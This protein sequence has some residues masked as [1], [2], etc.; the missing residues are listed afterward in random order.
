M[1]YARSPLLLIVSFVVFSACAKHSSDDDSSALTKEAYQ[2]G[3]AELATCSAPAVSGTTVTI[4][5]SATFHARQIFDNGNGDSGLGAA[6]GTAFPIRFAEIQVLRTDGSVAQCAQTDASGHFSFTLVK[7]NNA[8]TIAIYSRTPAS[9]THAHVSV[10][11]RPSQNQL[12]SVQG[13]VIAKG[14]TDI[15]VLDAPVTGN[16]LGGAFNIMDQIIRANLFLQTIAGHCSQ[17]FTGCQDF[18][19]APKVSAFWMKGFD[20]GSYFGGGIPLSYYLPHEARLFILGGLNGDVDASDT[21][22]FDNSVIV[23]EYGHFLED[24]VFAT[25]SPG[26]PHDGD[27]IVD[28]RLAWSEGWGDFI[29]AAVLGVPT[30][31]DTYGNANGSTGFYYDADI[32]TPHVGNDYPSSMGEGNFREFSVAR[33]LWDTIDNTPSEARF[34]FI[35]NIH[36]RFIEIWAALNRSQHGFRDPNYGFLNIGLLHTSQIYATANDPLHN[37][38]N[39]TQIRGLELQKGDNTDYGQS[40]TT[41]TCAP[42]SLT[43]VQVA[44]DDGSFETS[45][46]FRNNK[47]YYL[48]VTV[49]I[50]GT[51]DL[52]YQDADGVGTEA[53]LD[54]F[55]YDE[56]A[57]FANSAD[58]VGASGHD[59]DGNPATAET[60]S[61]SLSNLPPGKYLVNV[62]VRTAE[63]IG[64]AVNYQLKL[65]G[66]S[67][68]PA[69]L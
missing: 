43:P 68:C 12:Y 69:Q 56:E 46:L 35:D 55:L 7:G 33:F 44:G 28:P 26:G 38:S 6:P 10:L 34:G 23:H 59:P 21:D 31:Q 14:D 4:Q 65:N 37:G 58:I 22:Q 27:A 57:R 63:V 17:V 20:P 60:E 11:N 3:P 8:Y 50:S 62:H 16:V 49:P 39:F 13:A 32:E 47:F 53:D 19:V 45:D 48:K 5:G 66:S 9:D 15:G 54:L 64:G 18:T 29:Q 1:L 2:A 51:L 41:G 24:N 30:Y 52:I 61:I 25:S 67:L 40:I 42:W 36:D